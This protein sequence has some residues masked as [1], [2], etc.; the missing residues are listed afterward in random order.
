MPDQPSAGSPLCLTV[1]VEDWYRVMEQ[2][3]HGSRRHA[4]IAPN[5]NDRYPS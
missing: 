2:T 1:D 4:R 3:G 5:L